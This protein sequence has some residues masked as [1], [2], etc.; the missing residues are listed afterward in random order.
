MSRQKAL[1][2]DRDGV[3]N[4][5]HGYVHRPQDCDF[6]EGIFQLCHAASRKG[7]RIVIVTNQSGIAR[8]Y[9]S[10]CD[11]KVFSRWLEHQFWQHGIRI[12]HTYFC[13][14]HPKM[15]GRYGLSCTCRKPRP[16]MLIRA[17]QHFGLDFSRSI[18]VGDSLSDMRC[19]RLAGIKKSVLFGSDSIQYQS[20]FKPAALLQPG[21][22]PYYRASSLSAIRPLL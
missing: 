7:Y 18:M 17:R 13:P 10:E 4:V 16:G 1:L 19:A 12:S 5:N 21:N 9:Y 14:H 6:I 2:L 11:F 3:I 8:N 15:D 22:K 20:E